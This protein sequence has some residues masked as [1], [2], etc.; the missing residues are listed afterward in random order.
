MSGDLHWWADL[1]AI[2][3]F[4]VTL[5]TALVGIYGYIHYRLGFHEK[6]RRLEHYLKK[7]KEEDAKKGHKGQR[8]ALHITEHVGLTENEIIQ[9]SFRNPRIERLGKTNDAG[10]TVSLLFAYKPPN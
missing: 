8:T 6:S 10:F 5:V 4:V 9:I 3:T 2:A 7:E 1:T